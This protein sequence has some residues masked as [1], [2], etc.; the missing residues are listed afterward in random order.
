MNVDKSNVV[1]VDPEL[2]EL[3]VNGG[4][5]LSNSSDDDGFM[6]DGDGDTKI[7]SM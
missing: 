1:V 3:E 4:G 6:I 7:V 5:Y 2:E